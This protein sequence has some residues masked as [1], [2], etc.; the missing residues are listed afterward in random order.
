MKK[1]LFRIGFLFTVS[2][3]LLLQSCEKDFETINENPFSPTQVLMGPLFNEIVA[4]LRLGADR[5]FYLHNE[6]LYQVTQ[7]A[8]LTAETF[9]NFSIGTEDVWRNYYSALANARAIEQRFE[10]YPGDPEALINLQAQLKIIMAYKTLQITDLFGDI[11]Y[12]DAGLAYENVDAIR[13]KF[14][15]QEDIYKAVLEDL[16][17]ASANI[18]ISMTTAGEPVESF[19]NFDTFLGNNWDLWIKFSNSL[20]L[21]HLLRM[22]DK[23][24]AYADERIKTM[25]EGGASFL[26]N[27]DNILMSPRD[28]DWDNWPL[29]WSF[30]EHN[31]LR[32][33]SN[34]WNYFKDDA[35][36]TI[37]DPRAFIFFETNNEEE[38]VA[39]PQ[40]PDADTPQAGGEPY[41]QS[42]RDQS[43]SSKGEGNIYSNFNYYLVR[44]NKD[45]PEIIMTVAEVHFLLAEVFAR[46]IGVATDFSNADFNYR[47]GM[48]AS[49]NFWQDL[50]LNSPIWVNN[51]NEF[52][53][54]QLF[55]VSS[56]PK[57]KIQDLSDVESKLDL[58]YAQRWVDA[59]RQ[60]WEAFSLLR[61]TN[62]TPR[63]GASNNFFR[64]KYPPSE[65][66]NNP[67]EWASQVATMGADEN[68]IKVWW[69]N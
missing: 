58:I 45:I 3:F 59:F 56:H 57:Y 39:H 40:W 32:M 55:S 48:D 47:K 29:N 35:T 64:F 20:Q 18:G 42:R 49:Q 15:R 11:P 44:D 17:W 9:Q 10:E 36:D 26:V 31:K 1:S 16:A 30:R 8:A 53:S 25:L 69:M 60:P 43:Y 63:E 52:T 27:K 65:V 12:F 6:K 23:E 41:A 2:F 13:P 46:G 24:P 67:D 51:V 21:R 28:Q 19:E 37:V 50:M 34:L 7:L 4:S 14:D 61:R 66:N 54:G 5:Q 68:D 62:R 38:W 33:G 22:H